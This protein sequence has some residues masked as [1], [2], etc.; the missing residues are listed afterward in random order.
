MAG[1]KGDRKMKDETEEQGWRIFSPAHIE[2]TGP[3]LRVLTPEEMPD[4][5]DRLRTIIIKMADNMVMD[6]GFSEGPHRHTLWD[7][8]LDVLAQRDLKRIA[9]SDLPM[10]E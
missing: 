3:Q 5:I 4:E 1:A 10:F 2:E 7:D 6:C 8:V 9:E